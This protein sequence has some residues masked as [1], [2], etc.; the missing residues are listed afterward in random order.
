MNS[1]NRSALIDA[2]GKEVLSDLL[3]KTWRQQLAVILANLVNDKREHEEIA[4][5]AHLIGIDY[6]GRFLLELLQNGYDAIRRAGAKGGKISIVRQEDFIAIGNQGVPFDKDGLKAITSLAISDKDPSLDIGNKGVGFKSVFEVTHDPIIL[7]SSHR[8]L[9]WDPNGLRF[10]LSE[11]PFIKSRE[12]LAFLAEEVLCAHT[13]QT[14]QLSTDRATQIEQLIEAAHKAAGFKFPLDVTNQELETWAQRLP[15]LAGF[16]TVV[17]LPTE[18]KAFPKVQS[19]INELWSAL[20]EVSLFLPGLNQIELFDHSQD[21]NVT[22]RR[23]SKEK[24]TSVNPAV[25]VE[26]VRISRRGKEQGS[27]HIEKSVWWIASRELGSR[28]GH[29]KE[30]KEIRQAVIDL[31][32]RWQEVDCATVRVALPV[33]NPEGPFKKKG[34][35]AIGLPTEHETGTPFWVDS[36]FYSTISRKAIDFNQPYNGLLLRSATSLVEDLLDSL[37]RHPRIEHR[38]LVTFSRQLQN[39]AGELIKSLHNDDGCFNKQCFLSVSGD[40]LRML[41]VNDGLILMVTEGF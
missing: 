31:G 41:S 5:A 35:Y 22:V 28:G 3:T 15:E 13:E 14:D 9:D 4:S 6:R 33:P 12:K 27:S 11:T 25:R 7:S 20:D 8:A 37:K 29:E 34:L 10:K 38:R 23:K 1:R 40:K 21:K 18:G 36:A 24:V 30:A 2:T 39:P 19:A 26:R 16:E 32:R 17:I